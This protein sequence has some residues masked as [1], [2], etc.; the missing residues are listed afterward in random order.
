MPMRMPPS[1]WLTKSFFPKKRHSYN[2]IYD[3]IH[4][5]MI[6]NYRTRYI[7]YSNKTTITIT[8]DHW[9]DDTTIPEPHT[10]SRRRA[11]LPGNMC[12]RCRHRLR[13]SHIAAQSAF[14][15]QFVGK[16]PTI[17]TNAWLSRKPSNK[18][19]EKLPNNPNSENMINYSQYIWL[20]APASQYICN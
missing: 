8:E 11:A 7:Y 4:W 14:L 19:A 16:R 12:G 13:Q 10:K 2:I 18:H 15:S 17:Q 20:C 1:S 9:V 5:V 6:I 3:N